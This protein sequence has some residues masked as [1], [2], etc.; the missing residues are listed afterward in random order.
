MAINLLQHYFPQTQVTNFRT[1]QEIGNQTFRKYL[2]IN[3]LL[4]A[5]FRTFHLN[6]R[7]GTDGFIID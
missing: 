7:F 5:S 3:L 4:N 1:I 6:G 2:S